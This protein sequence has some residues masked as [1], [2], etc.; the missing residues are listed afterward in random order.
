[1]KAAA[2]SAAGRIGDGLVEGL[3]R[4]VRRDKD[5]YPGL[6]G[7][8]AL[9]QIGYDGRHRHVR[10]RPG[11]EPQARDARGL[12]EG[13]HGAVHEEGRGGPALPLASRTRRTTATRPSLALGRI[14][15]RGG[16]RDGARPRARD[17][18]R[19]T[20]EVPDAVI[21]RLVTMVER[22]RATG[23]SGTPPAP[24]LLRIGEPA[25]DDGPGTHCPNSVDFSD[26]DTR[27]TAIE[28]CGLFEAEGRVQERSTRSRIYDKSRTVRMFAARALEGI[29]P[30]TRRQGARRG[31]RRPRQEGPRLRA[32]RGAGPRLHPQATA[33]LRRPDQDH[34]DAARRTRRS[35][36]RS[37]SPWSG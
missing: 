5:D 7:V 29:D 18:Q 32:P 25:A 22:R 17:A 26:E 4:L 37:S 31:R 8:W 28:L 21:D 34:R 12:P 3:V 24:S 2:C 23:R 19:A 11:L 9:K 36:A 30:E 16:F 13:R 14:A 6:Y 1:M 35:C 27:L 20:Q 33:A 10:A 15:W